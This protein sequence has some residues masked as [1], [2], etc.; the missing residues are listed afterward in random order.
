MFDRASF[1]SPVPEWSRARLAGPQVRV[2]VDRPAT[3]WLVSGDLAAFLHRHGLARALGPREVADGSCHALRLAPDR[4]LFVCE[5]PRAGEFGWT[6]ER[7]AIS[8]LGD[9]LVCI[10]LEGEG[11]LEVLARASEYPFASAARHPH[12]SAQLMLAGLRVIVSR[13][14]G[15]WRL[16]VERPWAA[17]LWRWLEQNLEQ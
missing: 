14:V 8:D 12:E 13:R 10:A 3:L 4:L 15:G 7:C 17:A 16:L 1:W 5:E 9:G 2:G 6:S 11:A